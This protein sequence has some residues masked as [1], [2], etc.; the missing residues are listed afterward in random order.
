ML[1][2]SPL[3]TIKKHV[4]LY[5]VYSWQFALDKR[6][7]ERCCNA[8]EEENIS[9]YYSFFIFL[10]LLYLFYINGK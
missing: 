5:L 7:K 8:E 3:L 9:V 1:S 2:K 6:V 10:A 4:R